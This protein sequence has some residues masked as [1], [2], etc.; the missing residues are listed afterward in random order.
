MSTAID[1]FFDELKDRFRLLVR[2]TVMDELE[3]IRDLLIKPAG[4]RGW[5]Y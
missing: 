4:V 2:E 3:P 5:M 1:K